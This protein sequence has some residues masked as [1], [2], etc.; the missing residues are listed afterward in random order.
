MNS[1]PSELLVEIFHYLPATCLVQIERCCALFYDVLNNSDTVFDIYHARATPFFEAIDKHLVHIG[2]P[3]NKLACCA[4]WRYL[5]I[6]AQTYVSFWDEVQSML[7]KYGLKIYFYDPTVKDELPITEI[8]DY[9]AVFVFGDA[10]TFL[11]EEGSVAM[12]NALA[13][14]VDS[15]YGVVECVFANCNN[16]LRG[17][18][19]GRFKSENYHPMRTS[20][21]S[22]ITTNEALVNIIENDHI[23]TKN[24]TREMFYYENSIDVCPAPQEVLKEV[25]QDPTVKVVAEFNCSNKYPAVI[26]REMIK[27]RCGN[28][29]LL[30]FFPGHELA[31]ISGFARLAV[32][33]LIYCSFNKVAK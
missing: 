26:T 11:S 12:G 15:G 14:Y 20:S 21:Q 30:N 23:I 8:Y 24:C 18:L 27:P 1:L 16:C 13:D 22:T 4:E 28:I 29:A 19:A 6:G 9:R 31:K 3:Q 7:T 32:N 2:I 17:H 5:I 10:D 25:E 33:A